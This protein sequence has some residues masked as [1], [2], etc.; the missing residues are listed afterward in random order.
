MI[1]DI[2]MPLCWQGDSNVSVITQMFLC[3]F[4]YKSALCPLKIKK[5]SWT[6]KIWYHADWA[7]SSLRSLPTLPFLYL[8]SLLFLPFS[9]LSPLPS[10]LLCSLSFSASSY[11]SLGMFPFQTPRIHRVHP[12]ITLDWTGVSPQET[13]IWIWSSCLSYVVGTHGVNIMGDSR[14]LLWSK[15]VVVSFEFMLHFLWPGFFIFFLSLI[16]LPND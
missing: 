4:C 3:F 8:F 1:K 13:W 16:L 12:W 15:A 7:V 5:K 9:S 2:S 11:L 14:G 6:F 10:S